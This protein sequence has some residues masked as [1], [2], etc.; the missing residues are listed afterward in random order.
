MW[1]YNQ[2]PNRE[3]GLTPI[4]LITKRK[5]NHFD[6][7]CSHVWGCPAYVLEPK[8]QNGQKLPKW[9]RRSR[10]GQFLGYS[11]QHLSLVAN[12]RH[13]KTGYVSP[14]Y[15]VVYNDLFQTVFSAG[16]NTDLVYAMCEE[17]FNT[18]CEVYATDKYDAEDYLVYRPPPLDEVWLDYEG[19]HQSRDDLCRQRSCNDAQVRS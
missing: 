6:L 2:V 1:L 3:S 13:L 7:L 17:L 15:H 10:L 19:R 18:S 12:I 9:N 4:E 16:P 14:Q 8:L 5:S 11:D